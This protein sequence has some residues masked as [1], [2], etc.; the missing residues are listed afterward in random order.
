MND[1]LSKTDPVA[2]ALEIASDCGG[3]D[4]AHHKMWVIDQMVRALTGC[5]V[6]SDTARDCNGELY[7][8]QRQGESDAYRRWVQDF[9]HGDDG[10]HTY[11]WDVGIV[12]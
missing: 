11:A 2:K 7:T 8:F 1:G 12:P 4:G 5:P 10:P 9:Q 3:I 6:V